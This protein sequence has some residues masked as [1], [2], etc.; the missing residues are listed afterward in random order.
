MANSSDEGFTD[1]PYLH[2]FIGSLAKG[3]KN[4]QRN[5]IMR[6]AAAEMI[7]FFVGDSLEGIRL[8]RNML[9]GYQRIRNST[10]IGETANAGAPGKV[11]NHNMK[12]NTEEKPCLQTQGPYSPVI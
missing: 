6:S 11:N 2:K 1:E 4:S 5:V 9:G 3:Y 7:N 12:K 10:I 8:N